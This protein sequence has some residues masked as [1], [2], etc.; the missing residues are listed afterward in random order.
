MLIVTGG[1]G[2]IGANIIVSLNRQGRNDVLLV[3]DLEDTA[4]IGN[5]ANLDIADYE[6]KNRFLCQLQSAGLPAGV[7]AVFHQGACSDTLATDG[8]FVMENN[9]SYSKAMFAA[10]INAGVPMI[11]ASSA[12]VYGRGRPFIE[13]GSG[14]LPLNAYAYSKY[15][16]DCYVRGYGSGSTSQVVGLRYFN[17]YGPCENHKGRMASVAWHFYNQYRDSGRVRL[18]E[19]SGGYAHGEQRRDFVSVADVAAVNMFFLEHDQ[20][21]GIYNV[22][23]GVSRSFNDMALAVINACRQLD[24]AAPLTLGE[25]VADGVISYFPM[26]DTLNGKY[27][28]YTEADGGCLRGV[29]YSDAWLSLEEGVSAYVEQLEG[30]RTGA[31]PVTVSSNS[32]K[33]VH[34]EKKH[35]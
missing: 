20:I 6:D 25:A 26:P 11:Y 27:Q 2:F 17:V 28:S 23:T 9:F 7:E 24:S 29:G 32:D 16:F 1:A 30:Q 21:S 8:R 15:L 4:K 19:G 3:D 18:F 10:C 22:G 5:I 14:D 35:A 31:I 33:A 13:D 34:L 12:A